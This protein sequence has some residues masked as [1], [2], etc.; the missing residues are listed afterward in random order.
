[1]LAQPHNLARRPT[2]SRP[3]GQLARVGLL[4]V[5]WAACGDN[6]P[7]ATEGPPIASDPRMAAY[8]DAVALAE[9]SLGQAP[10]VM[11]STL[12]QLYYGAAWSRASANV[13][14]NFIITCTVEGPD[15]RP[16]LGA[17][18]H[19]ALSADTTATGQDV[20]HVFAVL[21][22]AV[23]PRPR[24]FGVD[25]R[26]EDFAGWPGDLGSSVA[27]H[28]VCG[29]LG[30]AAPAEPA[31]GGK[32]G[33][34]NFYLNLL[35]STADLN[36]DIDPL[37]M[38]AVEMGHSCAGSAGL[39]F[40]PQ[41]PMSS[42]LADYYLN[43]DSPLGRARRNRNRCLLELMGGEFRGDTL[44]N[45]DELIENYGS[46]IGANA[47]VYYLSVRPVGPSETER[48][49]MVVDGKIATGWFIDKLL[50]NFAS[51]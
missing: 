50:A 23:C 49:A 29:T 9:Q 44:L 13:L 22:A 10:L 45:R 2:R 27:V 7:P 33:D 51:L 40:E 48:N 42:L 34:L 17:P 28:A 36:G 19:T 12:R 5:G 1:M 16:T 47:A 15:P 20:G 11:L 4:M 38:R 21:E 30:P 25:M 24:V 8:I 46:Q 26:N 3:R 39:E 31:C 37:V 6:V 14:W 43:T 35:S 18:L 41:R 32:L